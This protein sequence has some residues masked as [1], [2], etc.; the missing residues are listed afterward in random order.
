[1]VEPVQLQPESRAIVLVVDDEPLNRELIR[2]VLHPRYQVLEAADATSAT[3]LLENG[4]RQVAVMICD[5]L[6]PGR[7]GTELAGEVR[8]RWPEIVVLLLTGY[9]DAPE[10]EVAKRN[11]DVFFVVAKPFLNASVLEG[12]ARA[13]GEHDRRRSC[14]A[15]LRA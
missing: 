2:R 11:G 14:S 9:D 3:K 4:G 12:V 5:H 1:M 6:M 13:I 7:S 10:V 15:P 8:S